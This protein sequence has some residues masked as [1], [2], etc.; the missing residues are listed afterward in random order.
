MVDE[1]RGGRLRCLRVFNQAN[2]A[3]DRVVNGRVREAN[4]QQAIRIDRTGIDMVANVLRD[5][6][7]FAGHRSL[8]DLGLAFDH[9]T[10][11]RHL[12]ARP[13]DHDVADAQA[14]NRHFADL[15]GHFNPSG[16]WYEADQSLDARSGMPRSDRFEKFAD[17]EQEYDDRRLFGCTDRDGPGSRHRHESFDAKWGAGQSA[18][19]STAR[20]GHE[21]DKRRRGISPKR[22]F[23]PCSRDDERKREDACEPQ[24]F[25]ALDCIPPGLIVGLAFARRVACAGDRFAQGLRSETER[26][27]FAL[28]DL[29]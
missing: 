6:N 21:P 15:A 22:E 14:L 23:G 5:E 9:A 27:D 29:S 26:P 24:N 11:G 2:D 20:D 8:V 16:A 4:T 12:V 1:T 25:A 3:R 19:E 28:D 7:G 18:D 10:V 17:R 13:N